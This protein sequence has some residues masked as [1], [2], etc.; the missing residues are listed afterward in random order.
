MKLTIDG[1][2][3]PPGTYNSKFVGIEETS[4]EEYGPGL[5][6]RFEILSGEQAGREATRVTGTK[7]TPRNACGKIL[8]SITGSQLVLGD[9][10]D[11]RDF[12]GREFLVAVQE[13]QSGATRV[14]TVLD[15]G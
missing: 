6:W 13:S 7:P 8:A 14:E 11:T 1:G 10:I 4:H 15:P 3:V 9:E 2:S 12:V 5:R